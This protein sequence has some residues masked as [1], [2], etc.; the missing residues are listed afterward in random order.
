[1]DILIVEDEQLASE[2]LQLLLKNYDPQINVVA[3]LE[4]I[5]ETIDWL[6]NNQEPDLLLMDIHLSDGQSFEILK[7]TSL[8]IPVIFTTAYDSYALDAF[9]EFSID[10]LLKPISKDALSKALNKYKAM[11]DNFITKKARK[12]PAAGPSAWATEE[13]Y[14]KRFLCKIGVRTYLLQTEEIAYFVAEQ[15]MVKAS[16]AENNL[17]VINHTIEK[18]AYMLD[19]TQFFRINRS[20]I[21]NINMIEQLKPHL[22]NRLKITLRNNKQNQEIIVSRE[23]VPAFREWLEGELVL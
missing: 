1:M 21:V 2:R 13:K 4:S 7:K 9:K 12:S 23:R 18:L 14:K 16:D 11:F 6:K 5:E 8:K 22:N 15:K 3:S 17:Y 19:P 20:M 10:Y